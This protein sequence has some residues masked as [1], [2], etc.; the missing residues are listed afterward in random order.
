MNGSDDASLRPIAPAPHRL[1]CVQQQTLRVRQGL[2]Y[3]QSVCLPEI[4]L[5]IRILPHYTDAGGVVVI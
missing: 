4:I 2:V 3:M 5:V 1:I